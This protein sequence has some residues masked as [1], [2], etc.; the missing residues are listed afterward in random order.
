[1][2]SFIVLF[3]ECKDCNGNGFIPNPIVEAVKLKAGIEWET[4]SDPEK[5]AYLADHAT[6]M[7]FDESRYSYAGRLF[8]NQ[9]IRCVA[10]K[11]EGFKGSRVSVEQLANT[12]KTINDGAQE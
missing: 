6:G 5:V 11:G 4:M 7:H 3:T 10:C 1:M 12:I 9:T 2:K 8:D